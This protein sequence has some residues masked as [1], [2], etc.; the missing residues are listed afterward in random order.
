[1]VA[2]SCGLAKLVQLA[3]WGASHLSPFVTC[4]R[5]TTRGKAA[6]KLTLITFFKLR[7]LSSAAPGWRPSA[8]APS[9][10]RASLGFEWAWASACTSAGLSKAPSAASTRWACFRVMLFAPPHAFACL[11]ASVCFS[12]AHWQ[13]VNPGLSPIR[14]AC[15]LRRLSASNIVL[16]CFLICIVYPPLCL[17]HTPNPQV[18][19][20]YLSPNVNMASRLEAATK[21]FKVPL[22][23]SRDFVMCLSPEVRGGRF[24]L[25]SQLLPVVVV[26]LWSLPA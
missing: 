2:F 13:M 6:T 10:R 22:L 17:T 7:L 15:R 21:Q 26:T 11:L 24:A 9:F 4:L 23:L 14:L 25:E 16:G 5:T 8:G 1:M 20:S 3:L 18:D 19:A 12:L